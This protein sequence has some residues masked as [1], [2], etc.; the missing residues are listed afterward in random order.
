MTKFF[1][2]RTV[3]AALLLPIL[4]TEASAKKY[5]D[6]KPGYTFT[7]RVEKVSSVE[8]TGIPGSGTTKKVGIPDGLPKFRKGQK[9]RFRIGSRGQLIFKGAKIPFL[10]D[11]GYSNLYRRTKPMS[12]AATDDGQVIKTKKNKA[13]AV[14]LNFTR[15]SGGPGRTVTYSLSYTLR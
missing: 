14:F 10:E 4:S 12:L 6:F 9:V 5:G 8:A 13:E 2:I 1:L 3:V 15:R 7:L 11:V